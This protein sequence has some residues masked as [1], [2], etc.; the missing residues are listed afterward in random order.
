MN[1][2][3]PL[4]GEG[5]KEGERKGGTLESISICSRNNVFISS[6]KFNFLLKSRSF[7]TP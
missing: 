4:E 2:L 5:E 7:K 1:G 3:P 6:V